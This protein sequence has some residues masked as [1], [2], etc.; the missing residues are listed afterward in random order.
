MVNRTSL[1]CLVLLACS[2]DTSEQE[3]AITDSNDDTSWFR[4][5]TQADIDDFERQ[6]DADH[7]AY[8]TEEPEP[9]HDPIEGST[10]ITRIAPHG[11]PA[12]DDGVAEFVGVGVGSGSDGGGCSG[13]T[14]TFSDSITLDAAFDISVLPQYVGTFG[15]I[16]EHHIWASGRAAGTARLTLSGSI[17]GSAS[18]WTATIAV[19]GRADTTV[20]I[21]ADQELVGRFRRQWFAIGD[22][23]LSGTAGFSDSVTFSQSCGGVTVSTPGT[24]AM[25]LSVTVDDFRFYGYFFPRLQGP[26]VTAVRGA[27]AQWARNFANRQLPGLIQPYVLSANQAYAAKKQELLGKLVAKLP[28]GCACAPVTAAAK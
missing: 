9:A 4:D 5:L 16:R 20:W 10:A 24:P 25:S 22:A 26:A 19:D 6:D 11:D 23:Q 21:H 8:P 14:V 2:V 1:A 28:A 15:P 13:A 27:L 18:S 12:D 3:V 7:D 17:T